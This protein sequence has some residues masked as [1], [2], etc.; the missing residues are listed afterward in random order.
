DQA[1]FRQAKV[2][3][4]ARLFYVGVT[5]AKRALFLSTHA[6]SPKRDGGMMKQTPALAFTLLANALS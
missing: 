5:R 2:S 1:R 3:E 4:E 6:Q